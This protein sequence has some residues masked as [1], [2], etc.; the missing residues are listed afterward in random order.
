MAVAHETERLI[1]V[2]DP[3]TEDVLM[4]VEAVDPDGVRRAA[5]RAR[6]AQPA[7]AALGWAQRRAV[8]R[9]CHRWLMAN[10]G[11]LVASIVAE[12]GKPAADALIEVVYCAAAFEYW[13]RMAPRYLRDERIRSFSPF[14][15]GRRM[16]TRR[17][18]VG[19]VGV[20]GP[21]N[22]PLLNSFGDAVPA[23]AAGN[24]VLLKPSERT[25]LT[26]LVM[27]E[28]AGP[29]AAFRTICSRWCRARR[30]PARRWSTSPTT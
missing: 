30:R 23:L 6:A 14:I 26:P 25:P 8:F 13:G 16:H 28:M 21:W 1:T 20:I 12:N 4:V 7:W 15:L 5:D 3:A 22:N 2:S 24:A 18:P 11:R 29:S 9:R 27:L 17:E 19:V 10:Q